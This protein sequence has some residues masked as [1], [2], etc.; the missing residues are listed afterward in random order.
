MTFKR[1]IGLVICLFTAMGITG[2]GAKPPSITPAVEKSLPAE[3]VPPLSIAEDPNKKVEPTFGTKPAPDTKDKPAPAA[4]TDAELLEKVSQRLLTVMA[5]LPPFVKKPTFEIVK[6][7][8]INA[9]AKAE[10]EGKGEELKVIPRV[11]VFSGLM[12]RVIKGKDDAA[13]AEDR[14]AFILSHELGHVYL[15]HIVQRPPGETA[16]VQ[17]VFTRDQESQADLKGMEM[18]LKAGFSFQRGRGAIHRMK[19]LGLNYS[20]FEGLG[21][22]H[23]SWNDRLTLM[24][25]DQAMLW[26]SM[27]A[28]QNGTF[29]LLFEQYAAAERCFQ[30]VTKEF[31]QCHEAWNNLG[32]ALLMQYCDDLDAD[33]LRQLG[34]GQVVVGGFYTRP[35]SLEPTARSMEDRTWKA[36]VAALEQALKLKPDLVLAKA[37]L[38]VAYLVAPRG[39]NVQKAR[40]YLQEAVEQMPSDKNLPPLAQAATL[41]NAG[42]AVLAAGQH[43]E[44]IALFARGEDTARKFVGDLPRAPVTFALFSALCYNRGLL[45]A[46]SPDEPL[47]RAALAEFERYLSVASPASSW[48]P[49]AQERYLKLCKDLD[50]KPK[51]NPQPASLKLSM[52]RLVTS[53]KLTPELTVA[54]SE[55]IT[56]VSARLGEG[57]RI[58]IVRGTKL[59]RVNYPDHGIE[60]LA[61]DRVLAIRLR[62]EKAPALPIQGRGVAGGAQTLRLGMSQEELDRILKDQPHEQRQLDQADIE[63]RYYPQLG[64][65]TRMQEDKLEELVV[66][67][68]PR[69]AGGE[70]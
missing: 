5:P 63:Y 36:A 13:G 61:A 41:I 21:V 54:L 45:L 34:I 20:S 68:I 62:G 65:A 58:P 67:Q 29:F 56:A 4:Q 39:T 12:E 33:D 27:S 42:V 8:K 22:D 6:D 23:P 51:E 40:Q 66:A 55:P 50:V 70:E 26:K 3:K 47:R 52:F 48:R 60:L 14:L 57:R 30:E 15:A 1:F 24:D 44:S 11:V 9:Y 35:Q 37:N 16:F 10:I 18:A 17:Q 46:A 49:L 19:E 38:G 25:K 28:F 64:L 43:K 59:V 53:V 69:R 32:Y 2:C 7:D 31:P